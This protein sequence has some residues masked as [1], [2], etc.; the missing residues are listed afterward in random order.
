MSNMSRPILPWRHQNSKI[1]KRTQQNPNFLIQHSNRLIEYFEVESK[2]YPP[3]KYQMLDRD[4]QEV[5][6]SRDHC[7][8]SSIA[9]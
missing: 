6:V 4:G 9:D 1:K 3:V 2:D 8:L 5:L 7:L